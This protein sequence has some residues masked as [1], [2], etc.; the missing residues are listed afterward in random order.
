MEELY[1]L[2]PISLAVSFL[3]INGYFKLADKLDIVDRPNERSSHKLVTIRGGAIV[4]PLV[5]IPLLLIF[6]QLWYLAGGLLIISAISL[7]DDFKPLKASRRVLVHFLAFGLMTLE[8]HPYI[9]F[10]WMYPIIFIVCVGAINAYNFM[11]GINGITGLNTLAILISVFLLNGEHEIIDS[12]LLVLFAAPLLAF[13]FYNFRGKA[14][15]FAGDVGSISIA[16]MIVFLLVKLILVTGQIEFIFL[17]GL[18][19][20]DSILT[21]FQRLLK[22]EN[23]FKP[24]RSHLYQVLANEVGWSHRQVS[25][26]YFTLQMSLNLIVIYLSSVS[27]DSLPLYVLMMY[28][29]LALIYFPLKSRLMRS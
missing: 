13:L 7:Y 26:V 11:D 8:L 20:I 28:V 5:V 22:R 19:G 4:F 29:P 12:N 23:I 2:F 24:H 10:W 3:L 25:A 14:K 27:N 16:F 1:Y 18:Y 6:T 21:L 15:C 9:P 17:M